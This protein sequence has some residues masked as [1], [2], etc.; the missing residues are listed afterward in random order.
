VLIETP[1]PPPRAA[2]ERDSAIIDL[3]TRSMAG[4]WAECM[5]DGLP[6]E[7]KN[8]SGMRW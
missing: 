5:R 1:P 8:G 4:R 6:T 2:A 7:D 3:L